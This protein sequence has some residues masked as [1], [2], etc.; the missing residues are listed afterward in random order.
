MRKVDWF[1]RVLFALVAGL[2]RAL[3]VALIGVLVV[4]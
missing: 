4:R 3:P 1:I 2:I